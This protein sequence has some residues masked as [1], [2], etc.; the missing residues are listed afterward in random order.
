MKTDGSNQK[1][2][3]KT[4]EKEDE[5]TLKQQLLKFIKPLEMALPPGVTPERILRIAM[6]AIQVS[7]SL[8]ACDSRSFMGS[9]LTAAQLGLEPNTPL[10]HCYLI[11]YW[12]KKKDCYV[13][14]FQ[15]GYQGMLELAYRSRLYKRIS[16]RVVYEGDTFSFSYGK[17]HHLNHIPKWKS[18]EPVF[19][20]A[21]YE[22]EN[23]GYDFSVWSWAAIMKHAE[24]FSDSIDSKYSPWKSSQTSKEEM[25]KK[26][27]L[28]SLLKYGPR[29]IEIAAEMT[30]A[31]SYDERIITANQVVN[32]KESA[33][34][35]EVQ[36]PDPAEK[37]PESKK[38]ADEKT[39]ADLK[40]SKLF[41]GEEGEDLEAQY[42]DGVE[43]PKF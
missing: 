6:T 5:G 4:E 35:F 26:T 19:V 31:I 32:G 13:C 25:A 20:Y 28:K 41:T 22:I 17:D 42:Q 33:V 10:G 43:P 16:A 12:D 21:D 34:T 40:E 7:K 29:S 38:Q 39:G 18:Q 24:E 23:G 37:K 30:K 14:N 2:E 3:T 15:M 27:V 11:P 36:T 9:L 1:T 8:A